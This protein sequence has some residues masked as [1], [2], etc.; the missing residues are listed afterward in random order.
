MVNPLLKDCKSIVDIM[1]ETTQIVSDYYIICDGCVI[2]LSFD[3]YQKL[4]IDM[5]NRLFKDG[6]DFTIDRDKN[7]YFIKLLNES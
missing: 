3:E 5:I 1:K 7:G 6:C 2:N 4:A